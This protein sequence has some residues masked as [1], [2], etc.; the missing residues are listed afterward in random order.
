MFLSSWSLFVI[1][2]DPLCIESLSPIYAACITKKRSFCVTER[3]GRKCLQEG[4]KEDLYHVIHKV[5][6]GDSPYVKAKH[7]QVYMLNLHF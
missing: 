2:V 1:G 5:P 6:Y 7:A 4:K 3:D